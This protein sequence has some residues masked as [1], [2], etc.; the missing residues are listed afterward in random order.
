[1]SSSELASFVRVADRK[2]LAEKG[3]IVATPGDRPLAVFDHDGDVFAIDNRCPHMGFPMHKG[4]VKDGIVTCHWHEARFEL[5]GGCTFDLW[6]DDVAAFETRVEGDDVFVCTSPRQPADRGYFLRRLNHGLQ[7][8]IS[9]I[10]AKSILGLR[11]LG[12][13]WTEIL[14]EVATFGAAHHDNWG[15]GMTLLTIAGNL[16]DRLSEE[17]AFHAVLRAARQ[18][19]LDCSEAVPAR[20]R[21][22]MSE[23]EPPAKRLSRWLNSW[24]QCRHRDAAERVVLTAVKQFGDSPE[25][26]DIVFTAANERVYAQIGH[27]FDATNKTFEL[28]D[29]IGW[30]YAAD[31]LPLVTQ[32]MVEARGVEE[33]SHWHHP[34]EIIEPLRQVEAELPT[35]LASDRVDWTEPDGLMDV[36][37][38]D[39]AQAI[40][41]LLKNELANGAPP[42]ELS[43]RICLA[44]AMR[45]AR[46]AMTNEVT[47]WFNPRHTFIYAN[48]VHQAIRRNPSPGIVRGLFH[49]ALSVYQDRFLNVP[50]ARLPDIGSVNQLP[51]DADELRD[52][53]LE[54]LNRHADVEA[55]AGI[56]L[57]YLRCG[58][59]P[60]RLID[61]LAFATS[62]EDLDFHAMQVLEAGVQQMEQWPDDPERREWIFVG[63]AR[64]LAAFC[65]TP[66]AAHQLAMIAKRLDRGEKMYENGEPV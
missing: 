39:D 6:A 45:L 52:A 60:N 5:C 62:R 25:L 12:V 51:D 18:V 57:R 40:I 34:V 23:G 17:T 46:F 63:I 50:A 1:M 65:P 32:Q 24:V 8:S 33:E 11:R 21:E 13:D 14:Q 27:V 19:A 49:A 26:N 20:E 61:T 44:A 10:Q 36:L 4:T 56:V 30:Q 55:A 3:V 47:D 54:T 2:E 7:H 22:P 59:D 31:L 41:D 48:A 35:L 16:V 64:Q 42:L 38:G 43:S 15:Q 58:H 28:L 53:M 66:R 37:L 29:N 9:L